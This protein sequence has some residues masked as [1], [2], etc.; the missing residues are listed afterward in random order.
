MPMAAVMIANPILYRDVAS[1]VHDAVTR[2][3]AQCTNKERHLVDTVRLKLALINLAFY[4]CWLPNLLNG[5][6]LWTLW[7]ELPDNVILALWYIMVSRSDETCG[8]ETS[9]SKSMRKKVSTSHLKNKKKNKCFRTKSWPSSWSPNI[10]S[11][12]AFRPLFFLL[13]ERYPKIHY[14]YQYRIYSRLA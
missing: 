2:S 4:V 10:P 9:K 12:E 8:E 6:L 7:Y 13:N 5:V 11:N 1:H 3:L 14:R